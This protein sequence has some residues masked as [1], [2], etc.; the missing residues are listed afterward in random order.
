MTNPATER[1]TTKKSK[2]FHASLKYPKMPNA[3]SFNNAS[4]RNTPAKTEFAMKSAF[5]HASVMSAWTMAMTRMFE[6]M[7]VRMTVSN[8]SVVTKSKMT[9]V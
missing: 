6:A 5:V 8:S 2:R 9:S 7:S 3:T 1:Q 4:I